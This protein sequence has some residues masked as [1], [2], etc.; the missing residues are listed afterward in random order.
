MA[1]GT[2]FRS[3]FAMAVSFSICKKNKIVRNPD[4]L[5]LLCHVGNIPYYGI[6]D[7]PDSTIL[8]CTVHRV[9]NWRK[10]N[11]KRSIRSSTKTSPIRD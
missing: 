9:L 2:T 8:R 4:F 3:V 11:K 10:N 7:T 5:L 6:Q 1:C